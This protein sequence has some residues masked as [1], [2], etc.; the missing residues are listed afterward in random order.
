MRALACAGRGAF[1]GAG[2]GLAVA[3]TATGVCLAL[4]GGIAAFGPPCSI[5]PM[6]PEPGAFA[7]QMLTGFMNESCQPRGRAI[8]STAASVKFRGNFD[9]NCSMNYGSQRRTRLNA[10][11]NRMCKSS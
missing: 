8:S 4:A 11:W 3:L 7:K 2:G 1:A 6:S 9:A 5:L 10:V